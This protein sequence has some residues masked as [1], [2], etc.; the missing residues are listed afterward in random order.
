MLAVIS[1][2][3]RCHDKSVCFI[4]NLSRVWWHTIST[5]S[6]LWEPSC[7]L[8]KS[9]QLLLKRGSYVC[10]L[11][12]GGGTA[13]TNVD[14]RPELQ[15]RCLCHVGHR[16]PWWFLLWTRS[17]SWEHLSTWSAWH[18]AK[19]SYMTGRWLEADFKTTH[20]RELLWNNFVLYYRFKAWTFSFWTLFFTVLDSIILLRVVIRRPCKVLDHL[21]KI[22]RLPEC[23]KAEFGDALKQKDVMLS[24]HHLAKD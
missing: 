6:R 15:F 5:G 1:S 22:V 11:A 13:R 3:V 2:S 19:H 21:W 17:L 10:R 24:N 9:A 16:P 18:V 8:F 20:T 23:A 7:L 12:P 14:D 4:E